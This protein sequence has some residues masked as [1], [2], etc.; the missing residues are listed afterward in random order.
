MIATG[1]RSQALQFINRRL[2]VKRPVRKAGAPQPLASEYR[3]AGLEAVTPNRQKA[4]H[5]AAAQARMNRAASQAQAIHRASRPIPAAAVHRAAVPREA[6]V[7]AAAPAAVR[8]PAEVPEVAAAL[9][10]GDNPGDIL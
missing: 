6:A 8:H 9:V 7:L 3:P 10:P 2:C 5:A 4:R 1:S